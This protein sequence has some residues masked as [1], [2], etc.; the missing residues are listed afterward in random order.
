MEKGEIVLY[1]PQNE[2]VSIDVLVENETVWLTQAQMAQ[3]FDTTRQNVGL[4][5]RNII[6]EN[7][8]DGLQLERIPFKFKRKAIVMYNEKQPTTI[9]I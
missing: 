7:E 5:I 4:H 1:K 8:L 2:S 3:L 6:K 9:W